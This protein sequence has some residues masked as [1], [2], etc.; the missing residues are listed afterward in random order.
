MSGALEIPRPDGVWRITHAF[1]K[2]TARGGFPGAYGYDLAVD[3]LR[4]ARSA[5]MPATALLAPAM[6]ASWMVNA[7]A[8]SRAFRR[9]LSPP[10]ASTFR[11]LVNVLSDSRG[12]RG[13]GDDERARAV[14][15]VETLIERASADGG[16]LAAVSKVLA[17]LC[18]AVVPLCDDAALWYALGSVPRSDTADAPSAGPEH[19]AP[20]L[21]WFAGAVDN[22]REPLEALAT[23][24]D[25]APLEAAQV[26]D[27]LVWFE[28]WGYRHS[29][30]GSG[31][32]WWWVKAGQRQAIVPL[33]P[34][35]PEPGGS[36]CV[37]L[38]ARGGDEWT[39]RARAVLDGAFAAG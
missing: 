24:Y 28:S 29:H 2:L 14:L 36:A 16:S 5:G 7:K 25:L 12:W 3:A 22:A 31:T 15:A 13:L 35:H 18:P 9:W 38:D 11:T 39:E 10:L 20:M 37:D 30:A 34:P 33:D 1:A 17:L 26:L 4:A 6:P 21:D 32:R 23:R 8:T 27:R 19:F